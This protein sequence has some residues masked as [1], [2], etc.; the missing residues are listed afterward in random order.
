MIKL[1]QALSAAILFAFTVAPAHA[2]SAAES[3][4]Y[5]YAVQRP[6]I[7]GGCPTCPWG[8]LA[9]IVRTIMQP[10]GWNVEQCYSCLGSNSVRI[11]AESRN[12]PQISEYG[13]LPLPPSPDAPVDFGVTSLRTLASGYAGAD[14]YAR[15]GP[16]ANLRAIARIEHP[17]Y[18]LV[19]T[20]AEAFITDL[21][22]IR[23]RR[24]PVRII[25][26]DRPATLRILEH[27]EITEEEL[28][29][30]G[31]SI[32]DRYS[33][34]HFDII[35]YSGYLG[36][37]PESDLWYETTQRANLRFIQ[38]PTNLLVRLLD[39]F[40]YF[41]RV[42]LP[43]GYFRGVDAPIQTVAQSGQVIYG[44]ADM[45][46][47]F[48]YLLAR[49]LDENRR[50][51]IWSHLMFHYD[52]NTAWRTAGVPLHPAAERYYRERGYMP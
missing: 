52:P 6:V 2:Q 14:A 16:Y 43:L 33:R 32:A 15:G 45:P 38:L 44:R 39:E 19:A 23:Q 49:T 11:V 7:G 28:T 13:R 37:S 25:S 29:S 12:A 40:D 51:F 21:A 4:I 20:R 41:E 46:D 17:S 3:E 47:E 27:Y 35:I 8:A 5:G 24:L 30:W 42:T 34:D 31:G 9:T 36:N 48:A 50:A 26:D 10:T 22:Q 1:I 18:L